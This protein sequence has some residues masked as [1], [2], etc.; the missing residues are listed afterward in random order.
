KGAVLFYGMVARMTFSSTSGGAVLVSAKH[1]SARDAEGFARSFIQDR[2]QQPP[3]LRGVRHPIELLRLRAG[4]S[5]VADRGTSA[6]DWFA[7]VLP[8]FAQRRGRLDLIGL[9]HLRV[10]HHFSRGV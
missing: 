3:G 9:A 4:R 7:Y 5:Y 2:L 1:P 8:T 6:W 10:K